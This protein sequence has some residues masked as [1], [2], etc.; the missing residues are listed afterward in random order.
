VEKSIIIE[1]EDCI[2]CLSQQVKALESALHAHTALDGE[3]SC[4]NR[5]DERPRA[6][7]LFS[8]YWRD[9]STG[10]TAQ[11]GGDE[12]EVSP[13]DDPSDDIASGLR[14]AAASDWVAT[15]T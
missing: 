8:D 7:C 13:R 1:D 3:W 9:T 2:C 14:T 6:L 15:R 11:S 10:P 12:Y 4:D 5:Y